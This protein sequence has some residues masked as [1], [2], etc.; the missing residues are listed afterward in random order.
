M[1]VA[2]SGFSTMLQRELT[3]IAMLWKVTSTRGTVKAFTDHSEDITHESVVYYSYN[4]F[5]PTDFVNKSDLS[6]D[7]LD[8][9]GV[10]NAGG[11]SETD[12]AGG[13]WDNATI[14]IKLINYEGDLDNDVM[15]IAD[16]RLGEISTQKIAFTTE[17][18]GKAERLQRQAGE[19]FSPNCR[20]VL[21]DSRCKFALENPGGE[22]MGLLLALTKP[23]DGN[24]FFISSVT[25]TGVT[26]R[27]TFSASALDQENGW[28]AGGKVRFVSGSNNGI[29]MEI[30]AFYNGTVTLSLPLP[31]TITSGDRFQI[32]TGCDKK[33]A[34]CKTKFDNVVN[35]RGEPHVP[36]LDKV[37]ETAGNR[38]ERD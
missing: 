26:N 3:T 10:L 16:G 32:T 25:V 29:E 24:N 11:I 6:V 27:Q 12:I 21:G 15:V 5:S 1:R 34:T 31:Y 13:V 2:G 7:S 17:L 30:K 20:A 28:F 8:V 37:L 36:G 22:P 18:R 23:L 14:Q 38:T 19:L 35:F 9:M 4:G 33:F